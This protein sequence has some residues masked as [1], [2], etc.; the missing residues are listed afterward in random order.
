[1]W[2][3]VPMI[4]DFMLLLSIETHACK[5]PSDNPELHL[6]IS[7]TSNNVLMPIIRAAQAAENL[8]HPEPL[9]GLP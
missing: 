1:M 5:T 2:Q 4:T 6:S 3:A 8:R 7:I 9:N